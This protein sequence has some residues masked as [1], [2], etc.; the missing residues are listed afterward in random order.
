MG[1]SGLGEGAVLF[2]SRLR[3]SLT[4]HP[5]RALRARLLSCFRRGRESKRTKAASVR[6]S[7]NDASHGEAPKPDYQRCRACAIASSSGM[8]RLGTSWSLAPL[9]HLRARK[10]LHVDGSHTSSNV[11]DRRPTHP[12]RVPTEG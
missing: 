10:A 3:R 9:L 5:S 7:L 8:E 12:P 11:M 4:G 2:F 6:A 1:M